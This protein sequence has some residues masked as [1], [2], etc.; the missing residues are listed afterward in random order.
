MEVVINNNFKIYN[1]LKNNHILR[2]I[3]LIMILNDFI[4]FKN[5][6]K[7]ERN[8]TILV[9]YMGKKYKKFFDFCYDYKYIYFF[10]KKNYYLFNLN[11]KK[12]I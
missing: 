12:F 1:Y 6:L 4:I 11:E 8:N 9:K 3:N 10:Y 2:K 7:H 5:V